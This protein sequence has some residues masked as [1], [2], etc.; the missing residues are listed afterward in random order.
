MPIL[1]EISLPLS[2]G[3]QTKNLSF[4]IVEKLEPSLIVGVNG[5]EHIGADVLVRK[6]CAVC[7][8]VEIPF[9]DCSKNDFWTL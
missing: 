4:L 6:S 5:L 7:L 9:D 3:V 2:L 1:G 8:G